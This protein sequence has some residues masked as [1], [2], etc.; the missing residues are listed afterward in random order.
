MRHRTR[1]SAIIASDTVGSNR[2]STIAISYPEPIMSNEL[3][4]PDSPLAVRSGRFNRTKKQFFLAQDIFNGIWE[5][6]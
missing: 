4:E 2:E 5:A 6:M 3:A 1:R